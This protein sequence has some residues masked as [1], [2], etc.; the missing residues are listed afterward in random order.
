LENPEKLHPNLTKLEYSMCLIRIAW[1]L[2]ESSELIEPNVDI[3]CSGFVYS[4]VTG[5]PA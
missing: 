1:G 5:K 3:F 2:G 4:L